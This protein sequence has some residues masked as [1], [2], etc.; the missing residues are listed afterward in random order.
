VVLN[1]NL[2]FRLIA[3]HVLAQQRRDEEGAGCITLGR[4]VELFWEQRQYTCRVPF[5][6]SNI[7]TLQSAPGYKQYKAF[8]GTLKEPSTEVN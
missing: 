7:A 1:T 8:A 5:D 4:Y 6:S 3:P 2:P